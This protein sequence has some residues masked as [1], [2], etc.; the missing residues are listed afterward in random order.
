MTT[1]PQLSVVDYAAWEKG[2]M[3][4]SEHVLV[5]MLSHEGAKVCCSTSGSGF[6]WWLVVKGDV[7]RKKL[8]KIGKI[9]HEQMCILDDDDEP[10]TTPDTEVSE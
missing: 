9:L 10:E 7:D 6:S 2:Y 3:P 5:H 4:P 1:P 8:A